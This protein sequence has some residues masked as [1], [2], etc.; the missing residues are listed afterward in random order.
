MLKK[1]SLLMLC[2]LA[3]A[4]AAIP[5]ISVEK[6]PKTLPQ[7]EGSLSKED[8]AKLSKTFG[9][10]LGKTL[11]SPAIGIPFDINSLVDGIKEGA[12][13][14]PAPL[15]EQQYEQL[16]LSV[17]TNYLKNLADKNLTSAEQFLEDNAKKED[18]KS[19]EGGKLQ[20]K[21][22]KEGKGPEVKEDSEVV[23]NYSGQF[24]DGTEF[25]SSDQSGPITISLDQTVPGFRKGLLGMKQG[26]KR[27]LFIHPD[28]GYGTSGELPPNSLLIFDIELLNVETDGNKEEDSQE[29]KEPKRNEVT[30]NYEYAPEY[31]E[32]RASS[33][34][35]LHEDYEIMEE[36]MYPNR[37]YSPRPNQSRHGTTEGTSNKPYAPFS[38][39]K[40]PFGGSSN[41][42]TPFGGSSSS[43]YPK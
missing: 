8:L 25:G 32:Q 36:D 3:V 18:V 23:I 27:K 11:V 41:T 17:Q 10:Y 34:Q 39:A 22:L 7:E 40:A 21:V 13:G 19:L 9:N 20:Y 5:L 12:A 29:E 2:S 24:I 26:E 1:T 37:H 16:L 4:L 28:L 31:E 14:K 6:N 15:D 38:N 35:L 43:G 33:P 30:Y 42:T